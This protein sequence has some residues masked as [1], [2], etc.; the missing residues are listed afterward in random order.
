M[1]ESQFVRVGDI[2]ICYEVHGRGPRVVMV[3][4]T[5]GDLR[6]NPLRD[7]HPLTRNFEVLMFDQRGLGRTSKPD[8]AYTMAGYA[9]DAVGLMDALGWERAHVIGISFGGMV[10]QHLVLDHPARVDRLV[11]MCTSSGGDGGDSFDLL[12]VN[13]LPASTRAHITLP[14]FDSRNDL[15]TDPPT[16]APVF[17]VL[18]PDIIAGVTLNAD[19]PDSA[20]GARRQLEARADHNTWDRLP[21]IT[22]PTLVAGGNYDL[23]SPPDNV[24]RLA[25]RIPHAQL[26]FFDGGHLFMLQEATTWPTITTF[27]AP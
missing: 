24:R 2:D 5:G 12:A 9:N 23:V 6:Q 25:A 7:R 8:Q 3:S 19:D 26:Q 11:L 17:D 13:D 20:L 15:S 14:R 27:L 4:G 22:A 21:S 16:W 1:I 10:A 18:G